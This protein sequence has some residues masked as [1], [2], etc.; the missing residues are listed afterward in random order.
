QASTSKTF[1]NQ[2][3]RLHKKHGVEWVTGGVDLPL[4]ESME[5]LIQLN[6]LRWGEQG[7]AF[8][9]PQFLAFHQEL[10]QT[11]APFGWLYLRLLRVDGTFAAAR[12][13]FLYDGKL[14]NNQNGWD[15]ALEHLSLGKMII[16]YSIRECI[17]LGAREYDF[18]GGASEYKRFWASNERNLLR[19]EV[20]NPAKRAGF[21][22]QQVHLL[23]GVIS[24]QKAA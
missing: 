24:P 13:D 4:E 11:I 16:G 10:A 17:A 15:P 12:Y 9:S 6:H 8:Q 3:N 14:W 2:W 5:T 23:K 22:L 7:E 20:A 19:V 1:K 18:L 21:F